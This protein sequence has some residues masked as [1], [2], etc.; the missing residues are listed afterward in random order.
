MFVAN[1]LPGSML[2]L[3]AWNPLFHI[4]DQCRGFVFINYN[5]HHSDWQYAWWWGVVLTVIGM[6]GEF[7]TRKYASLSW[8]ARR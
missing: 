1:M 7:Y 3:F 8:S 5:P 4:I 6:M 2:A